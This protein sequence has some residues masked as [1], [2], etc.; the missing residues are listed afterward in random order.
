M[1]SCALFKTQGLGLRIDRIGPVVQID[2]ANR[3]YL[4]QRSSDLDCHGITQRH[5]QL[6]SDG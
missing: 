1:V 6:I 2:Q 5:Q 4:R 3:Y